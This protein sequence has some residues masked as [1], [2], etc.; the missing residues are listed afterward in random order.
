MSALS[1]YWYDGQLIVSDLL[2][3]SPQEPGLLFG[4]TVFTTLR[5][6]EQTLDHPWTAWA[7]HIQRTARSLQAF[8]WPEPDWSRVRQGAEQLASQ[9]P[10]LRVTIFP[11]GRELILG[12][13][14]PPDLI[15]R[16]TAGITAWVADGADYDRPLP[17]HKTGNYLGCWLSLQTAQR[18]QAQEAIL[19]NDQGHWLETSTGNLWGWAEGEW[20]TPPLADGILP[21]VMRSRIL[22]GLQAHHQTPHMTPW[23]GDRIARLAYL[24]YTNSVMEVIPIRTVLQGTASVNYNPDQGKIQQLTKA[25]QMVPPEI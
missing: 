14:L 6:Y 19:V 23:D 25:W 13:S 21:G 4:A 12:R 5:V 1:R 2:A 18:H 8:H 16:Q 15:S 17:N 7:A 20:Y 9:Y 11:D 10:V 3:L 22:Q 24:V